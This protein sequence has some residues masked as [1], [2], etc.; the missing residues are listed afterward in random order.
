MKTAER[1]LVPVLLTLGVVATAGARQTYPPDPPWVTRTPDGSIHID[2]GLYD[3]E[4]PA[5]QNPGLTYA[6]P[7]RAPRAVLATLGYGPDGVGGTP[8]SSP[9][10][11][12]AQLR[13]LADAGDSGAA[14]RLWRFLRGNDES[15][16]SAR[17]A[18]DEWER[19]GHT[20]LIYEEGRIARYLEQRVFDGAVWF[21]LAARLGD[22]LADFQLR[23][24]LAS[25]DV[26]ERE[27]RH[28]IEKQLRKLTRRTA[29]ARANPSAPGTPP[30]LAAAALPQMAAQRPGSSPAIRSP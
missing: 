22:P 3:P 15:A 5:A 4:D 23:S 21:G 9:E 24:I 7:A 10:T 18:V 6:N 8:F 28:E 12:P 29:S 27:L 2:M 13:A 16:E 25:G 17:L 11:S 26:N 20:Y 19:H 1:W 14:V 30:R